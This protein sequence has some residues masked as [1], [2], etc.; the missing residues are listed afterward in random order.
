MTSRKMTEH[1]K[2][3]LKRRRRVAALKKKGSTNGQ[4]AKSVGISSSTVTRDLNWIEANEPERLKIDHA[5]KDERGSNAESSNSSNIALD[6]NKSALDDGSVKDEFSHASDDKDALRHVRTLPEHA[7]VNDDTLHGEDNASSSPNSNDTH[8][9]PSA[10]VTVNEVIQEENE[11]SSWDYV[12]EKICGSGEPSYYDDV[13]TWWNHESTPV[14]V[15]AIK[16]GGYR[17]ASK[18]EVR[19]AARDAEAA[20]EFYS[21]PDEDKYKYLKNKVQ[22]GRL[23]VA[24]GVTVVVAVLLVFAIIL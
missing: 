12:K 22:Q 17:N 10:R 18:A 15:A 11:D 1:Q 23:E 8:S 20:A 5:K 14:D 16:G 3:V 19:E 24:I 9:T 13:K 6:A 7:S 4:I 21:V 2:E